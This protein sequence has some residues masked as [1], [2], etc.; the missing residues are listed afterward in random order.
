M[1]RRKKTPAEKYPSKD[2]DQKEYR[3]HFGNIVDKY[4]I[5]LA[6]DSNA[7]LIVYIDTDNDIDW[8]IKTDPITDEA[9]KRERDKH[10]AKLDLAQASPCLNLSDKNIMRFKIMLGTGYK[11]AIY[12]NF[13]VVN[14]AIESALN[15]LKERN[16]EQS[17][18]LILSMSSGIIVLVTLLGLSFNLF[19]NQD[20]TNI[21]YGLLGAYVS[22]WSRFGKMNLTG[23][24][25][26]RIHYLE[27]FARM[28]CGA[29]FALIAMLLL[30]TGLILKDVV[31]N[32]VQ[33]LYGIVA[34][35]L[36][37]NER[38]VPSIIEAMTKTSENQN[39]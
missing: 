11:S 17:R 6:N 1:L 26:K 4:L 37:F 31:T 3:K 9:I 7:D 35:A 8:I 21:E 14:Y 38:F 33:A 10:I 27:A 16:K 19:L 32:N 13:D 5:H 36:G 34:F 39:E 22:I 29:I 2:D 25:S 24:A 18:Y 15:F 30:K 12:G 28:M 20:V 23:L